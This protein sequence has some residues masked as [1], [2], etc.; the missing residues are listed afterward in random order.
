MHCTTR[1]LLKPVHD[2][3]CYRNLLSTIS[4]YNLIYETTSEQNELNNY[5]AYHTLAVVQVWAEFRWRF[6]ISQRTFPSF[7]HCLLKI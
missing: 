4:S 3:Y 5:L 7:V 1:T 2:K 6:S